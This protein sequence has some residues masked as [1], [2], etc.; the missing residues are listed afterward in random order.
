MADGC[1]VGGCTG[2][3]QMPPSGRR[4]A[5]DKRFAWRLSSRYGSPLAR[6]PGL[7]EWTGQAWLVPARVAFSTIDGNSTLSSILDG[8]LT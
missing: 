2:S 4:G 1:E 6:S 7:P 8:V 3:A 5:L